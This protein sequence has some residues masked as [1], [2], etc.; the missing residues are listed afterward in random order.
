[1]GDSCGAPAAAHSDSKIHRC[2]AVQPGPPCSWGQPGA[3][4]P[5]SCKA[6]CHGVTMSGSEK[7]EAFR[8]LARRSSGER[9]AAINARTSSLNRNSS[10]VNDSDMTDLIRWGVAKQPGMTLQM[11]VH[12]SE[13]R[14]ESQQSFEKEA[15]I[16]L[17]RDAH[18][19]VEL[20]C[21]LRD[22]A[23]AAADLNLGAGRG[24]RPLCRIA[25]R[26]HEKRRTRRHRSGL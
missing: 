22:V 26:A 23:R 8:E 1:M 21:L 20:H 18:R 11:V 6:L 9:R 14:F 5:R 25:I 2:V 15:E 24:E 4:Q 7:K 12:A 10:G 3:T 13:K 19:A 17:V 16:E